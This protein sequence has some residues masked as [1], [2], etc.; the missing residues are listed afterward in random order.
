[1]PSLKISKNLNKSFQETSY[2]HDLC[3]EALIEDLYQPWRY[4]VKEREAKISEVLQLLNHEHE[5]EL[6]SNIFQASN[7]SMPTN[8]ELTCNNAMH[9]TTVLVVELN[10]LNTQKLLGR[11]VAGLITTFLVLPTF[12]AYAFDLDAGI[13]AVVDPFAKGV[14]DHYGKAILI[15][16]AGGAVVANGDLRTRAFGFGIG[17]GLAGAAVLMVKA[18]L[19]IA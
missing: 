16:G 14:V 4:S 17:S 11:V 6:T 12:S 3:V 5:P 15:L 18:T 8:I 9:T 10:K 1:M 2:D 19:G 7:K 13:K